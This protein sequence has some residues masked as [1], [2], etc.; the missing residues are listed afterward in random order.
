M[1]L[2]IFT[3]FPVESYSRAG[4]DVIAM[5]YFPDGYKGVYVDAGCYLPVDYSNTYKMYLSGWRGLCIDANPEFA[6][7]YA[8]TRPEDTFVNSGL[9][10]QHGQLTFY[11]T[12]EDLSSSTFVKQQAELLKKRANMTV[13]EIPI[14]VRPL[15]EVLTEQGVKHIDVLNIDIEFLDEAIILDF[16]FNR[17]QP[18]VILIEDLFFLSHQPQA[19]TIFQWL[20]KVGYT[21]AARCL[22]TCIY[23]AP[24]TDAEKAHHA[25]EMTPVPAAG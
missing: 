21:L 6:A 22:H 14:A 13:T 15:N 9:A 12:E 10:P 5:Q 17:W 7:K 1:S 4:E 3:R 20:T 8:E 2:S 23:V 24:A 25:R 11:R 19:S 18:R 16:D